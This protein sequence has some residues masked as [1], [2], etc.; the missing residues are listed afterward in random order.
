MSKKKPKKENG[1]QDKATKVIILITA[2]LSL[3]KAIIE[4]I[5]SMS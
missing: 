1:N 2:V 4:L 3:V 5:K